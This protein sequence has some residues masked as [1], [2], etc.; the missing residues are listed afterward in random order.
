MH[1]LSFITPITRRL[2]IS[3]NFLT[4]SGTKMLFDGISRMRKQVNHGLSDT[5]G[6]DEVFTLREVNLGGN[7]LGDEALECVL[8]YAKKDPGM[9][10]LHVQSNE[11]QVNQCFCQWYRDADNT[12]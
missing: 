2:D 3:H 7:G 5:A 11:C 1:I 8:R 10:K 9:R 12:S 4:L 6:V